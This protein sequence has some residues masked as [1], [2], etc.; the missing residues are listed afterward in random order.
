MLN[1][2]HTCA[3]C[4]RA[5]GCEC[6]NPKDSELICEGCDYEN[7]LEDYQIKNEEMF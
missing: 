1:H 2:E 5:F 6:S 3:E 7:R 4:G